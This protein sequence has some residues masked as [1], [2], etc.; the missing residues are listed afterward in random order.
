M[1]TYKRNCTI[2]YKKCNEGKDFSSCAYSECSAYDQ[3]NNCVNWSSQSLNQNNCLNKCCDGFTSGSVFNEPS[4]NLCI[5]RDAYNTDNINIGLTIG[6]ILSLLALLFFA[7][8]ACLLVMICIDNDGNKSS[9]I[10]SAEGINTLRFNTKP[11]F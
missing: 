2:C 6:L 4:F 8:L 3:N 7:G 5:E 1:Q 9:N 11:N 10:P